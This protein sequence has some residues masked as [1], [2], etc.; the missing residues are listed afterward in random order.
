MYRVCANRPGYLPDMVPA[1]YA[2]RDDAFEALFY[3]LWVNDAPNSVLDSATNETAREYCV[4]VDGIVY[5]VTQV[6]PDLENV[7]DRA[8]L[9]GPDASGVVGYVTRD[10]AILCRECWTMDPDTTDSPLLGWTGES[11]HIT[12]CDNCSSVLDVALTHDGVD[13]LAERLTTD[14]PR[15]ACGE[16]TLRVLATMA[17]IYS[18]ALS[19]RGI[20][21]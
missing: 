7:V 10:G 15:H 18:C 8:N 16:A 12:Q 9:I 5:E 3:E 19:D 20:T 17:E 2:S 1:F 6:G 11:D 14:A 4:T 13:L 21:I